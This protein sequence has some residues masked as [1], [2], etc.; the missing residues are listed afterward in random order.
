MEENQ[1]CEKKKGE[2]KESQAPIDPCVWYRCTHVDYAPDPEART[3]VIHCPG[4]YQD[5]SSADIGCQ[6][7]QTNVVPKSLQHDV[8][9]MMMVQGPYGP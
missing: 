5:E 6:A 8:Y 3:R 9:F 1:N 2:K 7:G 4:G